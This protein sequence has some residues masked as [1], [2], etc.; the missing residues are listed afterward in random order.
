MLAADEESPE[1]QSFRAEMC[2][3]QIIGGEGACRYYLSKLTDSDQFALWTDEFLDN[4]QEYVVQKTNGAAACFPFDLNTISFMA[5]LLKLAC[6][7]ARSGDAHKQT[8][9]ER[10]VVLLLHHPSWS[11]QQIAEQVPTTVK[12]LQRNSN[13]TALKSSMKRRR[14]T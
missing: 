6:C 5:P 14:T 2:D 8:R 4:M 7:N 11:D 1:H 3:L 12:Q 13:Y 9:Q 10:A